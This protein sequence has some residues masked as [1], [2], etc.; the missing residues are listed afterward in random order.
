MV[1]Y[2]NIT[3]ACLTD[4]QNSCLQHTVAGTRQQQPVQVWHHLCGGL[5]INVH[6]SLL[7]HTLCCLL[8]LLTTL[9]SPFQLF[10]LRVIHMA[11]P[12]DSGRVQCFISA[13]GGGCVVEQ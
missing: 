11:C 4:S 6:D 3:N 7:I 10:L 13:R 5:C 1:L 9:R 8:M 12:V 2:C